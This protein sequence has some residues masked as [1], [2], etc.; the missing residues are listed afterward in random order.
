[1]SESN[2]RSALEVDH[3]VREWSVSCPRLR[4]D[5]RFHFQQ[6]K[7]GP[8]YVIEDLANR[9]YVQIGLPE[10][11]FLRSLDGEKNVSKLIAENARRHRENALDEGEVISLLRWL[12]EQDFLQPL[13]ADQS[14]RRHELG[15]SA[16]KQKAKGVA[17]LLFMKIPI[18]NPDRFFSHAATLFGWTLSTPVFVAW[19]VLV[20]VALVMVADDF[21]SLGVT[22]GAV[23]LP[24]NWL[25]LLGVFVV[26]KFVHEVWH[27]IA[28]KRFGGIVPEW[29]VQ[30]IAMITPLTYV[31]ASASWS[32]PTRRQ[33]WVVAAAGMYVELGIAAVAVLVWS[34]TSAG[35]ANTLAANVILVAS[36]V[37][38]LFN[39]NPLMRFDGYYMLSDAV[40]IRNLGTKGTMMQ[41][42]LAKRLILGM[43]SLPLPVGTVNDRYLL[44][45]YGLASAVWRLLLMFSILI[46]VANLFRG[47]GV[48]LAV[49]S[50][51]GALGTGVWKLGRFLWSR[52]NGINLPVALGRIAAMVLVSGGILYFV[53]VNPAATAPTVVRYAGKEVVRVDCPGFVEEVKVVS[54]Q[55]VEVGEVLFSI[56]NPEEVAMLDKIQVEVSRAELESLDHFREDEPALFEASGKKVEGLRERLAS[57]TEKV[58]SLMVQAPISGTVLLDDRSRFKGRYLS[59]GEALLS[60]VPGDGR[61]LVIAA[62]PESISSLRGEGDQEVRVRLFGHDNEM[63][64]VLQRIESR[65]TTGLPHPALSAA[66]GGPLPVRSGFSERSEREKTPGG[67]QY[68]GEAFSHFS[69]LSRELDTGAQQ[70]IQPRI[71]AYATLDLKTPGLAGLREGEWGYVRFKGGIERRLGSWLGYKLYNLIIEGVNQGSDPV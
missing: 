35:I 66:F 70:L 31:D 38:V 4:G 49:L 29:G 13:S 51:A 40:G 61:E 48:V 64:A 30:L 2:D 32:L 69:G 1:M 65:A 68:Q 42:W 55:Q 10:Y 7:D 67:D 71:A 39:A 14:S 20:L 54:G 45:I 22:L 9:K 19:M 50:F 15:Q 11:Q 16:P 44:G 53:Q 57:Q 63:A 18:G 47:A 3:A 56:V 37:T 36:M 26:L 58:A 34:A 28:M 27:G 60:I 46:I 41:Q 43:K 17:A 23:I 25:M 52:E 8:V 6:D 24:S 12:L 33:R 21:R 62:S 5:I 59:T